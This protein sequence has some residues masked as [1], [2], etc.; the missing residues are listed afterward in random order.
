[1]MGTLPTLLLG[2]ILITEDGEASPPS[3][4][5]LVESKYWWESPAQ[6]N[7]K[8]LQRRE[9]EDEWYKHRH[10]QKYKNIR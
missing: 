9:E 10:E 2:V 8:W 5:Y 4:L 6:P 1:M 3:R 7:E